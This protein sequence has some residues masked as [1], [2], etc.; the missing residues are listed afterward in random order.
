MIKKLLTAITFVFSLSGVYAQ[1]VTYG[2]TAGPNLTKLPTYANSDD[3][4]ASVTNNYLAGF[5]VGG[6]VDIKFNSF[7]IQPGVV[8][9]QPKAVKVIL[10]FL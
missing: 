8:C 4:G 10:I 9:L 5:H 7:I 1:T 3:D 2:V 6:L